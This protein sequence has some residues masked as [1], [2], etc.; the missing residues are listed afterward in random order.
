MICNKNFKFPYPWSDKK[1]VNTIRPTPSIIGPNVITE[2]IAT[3]IISEPGTGL[4]ILFKREYFPVQYIKKSPITE[5]KG[6]IGC[7]GVKKHDIK[8]RLAT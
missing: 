2:L 6:I 1:S 5:T 8:N 3:F 7:I 4:F